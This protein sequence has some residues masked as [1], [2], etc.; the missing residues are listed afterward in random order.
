VTGEL[1]Q[2]PEA[3]RMRSVWLV[4]I[5]TAVLS[6]VLIAIAWWLVE[7]ARPPNHA[8]EGPSTLETDLFDD[9]SAGRQLHELG[10]ARIHRYDWVD[11]EAGLVHIPIDRAIDAVV[12]NPELIHHRAA[13]SG[14]VGR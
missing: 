4:M 5:A 7:P 9:A 6:A 10:E 14:E 2:D 8:P 1:R 12:A 13:G 11:R 3:I